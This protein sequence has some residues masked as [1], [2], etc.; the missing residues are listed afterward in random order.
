MEF[1]PTANGAASASCATGRS[2]T[3]QHL[4]TIA[5]IDERIADD[6]QRYITAYFAGDQGEAEFWVYEIARLENLRNIV[7][8]QAAA[9]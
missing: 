5:E 7:Q 1:R 3:P 2:T 8:R 9:S 4:S 6:R